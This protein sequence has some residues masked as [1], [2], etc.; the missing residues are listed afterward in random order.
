[1]AGF[2]HCG[3]IQ[4][5]S[6]VYERQEHYP[7][8]GGTKVV[9]GGRLIEGGPHGMCSDVFYAVGLIDLPFSFVA[10][11]ILLPYSLP[12]S[13]MR[14]REDAP[15]RMLK[16]ASEAIAAG[17]TGRVRQFLNEGVNPD[18]IYDGACL[19]D[20]AAGKTD[21][22]ELLASRGAKR[23]CNVEPQP[24]SADR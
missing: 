1:M 3:T 14:Y 15:V 9:A 20:R 10:D 21:I 2:L 24:P 7:V 6:D 12:A 5:Y 22:R 8:Y 23:S 13:V 16:E 19:W 11:T 18:A 4:Y 17:D